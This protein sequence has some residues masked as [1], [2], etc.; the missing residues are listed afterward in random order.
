MAVVA[1]VFVPVVIGYQLWVY[2]VFRRKVV[3]D[4]E[5]AGGDY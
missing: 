4:V 2:R 3:V 5:P 1:L